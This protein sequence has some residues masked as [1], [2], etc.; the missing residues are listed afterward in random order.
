MKLTIAAFQSKYG[1]IIIVKHDE[2]G[3]CWADADADYVRLTH[4]LEVELEDLDRE[5]IVTARLKTLDAHEEKI[6]D[7]Y[8]RA[9]AGIKDQREKLLALP[10]HVTEKV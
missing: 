4:P 1:S 5:Q 9:I 7:D 8:H 3:K 6:K 2:D 10:D